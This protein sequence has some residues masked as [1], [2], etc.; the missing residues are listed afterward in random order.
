M[1]FKEKFGFGVLIVLF[2]LMLIFGTKAPL[3]EDIT[4]VL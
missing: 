3:E 4:V 1:K 2:I